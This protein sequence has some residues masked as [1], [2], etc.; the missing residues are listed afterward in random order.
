MAEAQSQTPQ[1]SWD[2]GLAEVPRGGVALGE[3][4]LMVLCR[5]GGFQLSQCWSG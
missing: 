5:V 4:H 2:V 3:A 1:S